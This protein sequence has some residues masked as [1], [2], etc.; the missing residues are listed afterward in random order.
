[1]V[2]PLA[3]DG[4][5]SLS[6]GSLANAAA[7]VVAAYLLA[8]AIAYVLSTLA[9]R[10]VQ[11]RFRVTSFIPVLKFCIYGGAAYLVLTTLFELTTTQLVAFSGLLGAAIGLGLKDFLADIVGGLVVVVEQP[12][13]VGDKVSLGDHYGEVT[14]IGLRSTRLVTP[15][16]TAVVVPNFTAVNES[17]ANNNTSAAEMLVIVEFH[18]A[19]ESDTARAVEIVEEAL[20][21][22][23]YVYVS[24]DHPCTVLVSDEQYYQTLTGR[25][26]VND[27]RNE[28]L[29]QTD[30]TRRVLAAF[31]EADIESPTAPTTGAEM[32]PGR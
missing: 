13:Q 2:V 9:D 12:Y 21:S 1:V 7:V 18:V 11:H 17:L 27:L 29:F 15:N 24:D 20:L 4:G 22:S 14:S 25:A 23:R 19:P 30:V 32:P 28:R 5:A 3:T 16:D 26:Y 10:A 8:R 31:D 6:P